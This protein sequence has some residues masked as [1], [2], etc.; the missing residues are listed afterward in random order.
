M[1]EDTE[2][3]SRSLVA[4][5]V[6]LLNSLFFLFVV[7]WFVPIFALSACGQS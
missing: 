5:I 3:D 4:F 1:L 7:V 2:K 6:M